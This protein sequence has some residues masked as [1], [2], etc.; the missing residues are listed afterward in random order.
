[1]VDKLVEIGS[2]N[3]ASLRNMYA[4]D[5]PNTY[6]AHCTVENYIKWLEKEPGTHDWH[7]YSL[8]GDWSDGTYLVV[9]IHSRK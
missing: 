3:W 8:N 2:E 7:I 6:Y 9:V 4:V 1:M 5:D